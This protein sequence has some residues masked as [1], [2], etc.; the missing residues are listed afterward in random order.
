MQAADAT[1]KF[2]RQSLLADASNTETIMTHASMVFIGDTIA[3]KLKRP[4]HYSY[5]DFSTPEKRRAA[6]EKE[7]ELNRRTAPD[8]YLRT[9]LI[10]R[11]EGGSLQ[12]DLPGELV[13]AIIEMRR[14]DQENLFDAL[15]QSGK[16]TRSLM[17]DLAGAIARFHA[18]APVS[19]DQKGAA[20]I[21][22]VLNIN[23]QALRS[24]G[25]M[26]PAYFQTL[27]SKFTRAFDKYAP[28]LDRRAA[29][30]KVR[31]CHGDLT[32]RNICLYEGK[33]LL[34]DCLEFNEDLAT[35]DVL[36]DLAFLLMD[37]WHRNQCDLA[38]WCFNRYFDLRD[39]TGGIALLP[40]F[41]AMRACVRAHVSATQAADLQDGRDTLLAE[42]RDY[43]A[44]AEKCLEDFPPLLVAIGGLSGTGK[45]TVAAALAWQTGGP[46]G[47]R[48]LSS[49][50]IRKHMFGV[51]PAVRLPA[52]AYKPEISGRVYADVRLK[53]AAILETGAAC[54]VESVFDRAVDRAAIA[55]MA[56]ERSVAFKGLWLEVSPATAAER[57]KARRNDPSDATVDVLQ[58]QL[59]NDIG[60]L[61]WT[62]IDAGEPLE[63][64][65]QQGVLAIQIRAFSSEMDPG[66][67]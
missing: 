60:P 13:D 8:L 35:I 47:A 56:I 22:Y 40:F 44:L 26:P 28:L 50:R 36:Y 5:L 59:I 15:A 62:R 61:D 24:S 31:R 34:F 64:T 55:A 12:F 58:A 42:A 66:S 54:M 41:M 1:V 65:I 51:D 48:I 4:V 57:I 30:G 49:D 10:T 67:R 53:S 21:K 7:L 2:L 39:E 33:P 9:R 17:S 6:C 20:R 18:I 29:N 14:F 46:P 32:L 43:L 25:L 38:N 52:E 23:D 63:K 37:L 3:L 16:L 45:S 27:N 11:G 19:A